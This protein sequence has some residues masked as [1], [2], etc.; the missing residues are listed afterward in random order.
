M[1]NFLLPSNTS[2][3]VGTGGKSG[4]VVATTGGGSDLLAILQQQRAAKQS[5]LNTASSS[6]KAN[7]APS[8]SSSSNKKVTTVGEEAA[9][10][11]SVGSKRARPK[12]EENILNGT[13][14]QH[15]ASHSAW[16]ARD[17]HNVSLLDLTCDQRLQQ[18][19]A[20]NFTGWKLNKEGNRVYTTFRHGHRVEGSGQE[21]YFLAMGDGAIKK[22]KTTT[23]VS[24]LVTPYQPAVAAVSKK[25]S[26]KSTASTK[27]NKPNSNN[28]TDGQAKLTNFFTL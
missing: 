19:Q 3:T 14:S 26:D 7:T 20:K 1:N 27:T 11:V 10:T 23:D 18:I 4:G 6:S 13:S 8:T 15:A 25:T 5:L 2:K 21:A 22:K 16:E 12:D 9:K 17:Q 28:N 24:E